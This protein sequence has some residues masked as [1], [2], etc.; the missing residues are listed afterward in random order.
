[1]KVKKSHRAIWLKIF[2]LLLAIVIWIY[3]N[4]IVQRISGGPIAYKDLEEVAILVMGEP[5]VLGKNVVSVE[6]EKNFIDLR[7][8]G[9]EQ[10]IEQLTQMDVTAYVNVTGLKSG[11]TYS[12]VVKFVMPS[13]M[14]IVGASPLIRVEIKEVL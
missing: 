9:P 5:V 3:I 7:V 12:P 8:K 4:G 11:K 6:L 13:N 14:S 10:E 1:M 2:S